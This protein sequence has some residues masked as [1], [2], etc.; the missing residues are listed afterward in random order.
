MI[1]FNYIYPSPMAN[2]TEDL[3]LFETLNE[4]YIIWSSKILLYNLGRSRSIIHLI[5]R[6]CLENI[7]MSVVE[8][9]YGLR[10]TGLGVLKFR[11][12]DNKNSLNLFTI[13]ENFGSIHVTW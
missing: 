12:D 4:C 9:I 2:S 7:N 13:S 8:K 6:V 10:Q 3:L 1:A 5:S 11:S